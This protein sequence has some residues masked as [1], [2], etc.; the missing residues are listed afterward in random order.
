MVASAKVTRSSINVFKLWLTDRGTFPIVIIA[1]GAAVAASSV[2]LRYLFANP[3]VYFDKERRER[4]IHH[5]G[6]AGASWR[7]FRF[8]MAN[9]AR[10]PINQSRQFDLMFEK[11]ENK[12]VKR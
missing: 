11:P 4:V 7:Q 1:S 12:D 10:N 9:L 8:R 5:E 2:A 3:D 6:D